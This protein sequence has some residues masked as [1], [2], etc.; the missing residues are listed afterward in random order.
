MSREIGR[1]LSNLS[2]DSLSNYLGVCM[3]VVH[4]CGFMYGYVHRVCLFIVGR[5]GVA[6]ASDSASP[7]MCV[8]IY[9]YDIHMYTYIYIYIYIYT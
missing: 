5:L 1:S 9:I 6:S 3:F 8:Y 2:R 7:N 4:Y